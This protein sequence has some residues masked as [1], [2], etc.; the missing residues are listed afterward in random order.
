VEFGDFQGQPPPPPPP[1]LP[2]QQQLHVGQETIVGPGPAPPLLT[3]TDA[4]NLLVRAGHKRYFFDA[5]SNLH[6]EFLRITEVTYPPLLWEQV[7]VT[8]ALLIVHVT[9][10]VY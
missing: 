10:V 1:Q 7:S 5:C 6:G 4:G 9:G 8:S 2:P 3:T